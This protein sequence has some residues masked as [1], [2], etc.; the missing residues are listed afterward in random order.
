MF[1]SKQRHLIIPQS[2]HLRLVGTL[3]LLWGNDEF[4]LP[5]I[6][7]QSFVSGIGMHDR[8]YGFLDNAP[9]GEVA[10]AD[11]I[12]ITRRGFYTPWSNAAADLIAKHHLLRLARH[13]QSPERLRLTAEFEHAISGI[14]QQFGFSAELFARIDRITD[15]CDSVSFDFCFDKPANGNVTVFPRNA[16]STE[17]SIDYS[18]GQGIIRMNPWPFSVTY[19]QGYI[20]SYQQVGYPDRLDPVVLPWELFRE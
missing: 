20:I 3:A 10:E 1:K 5:D 16:K 18:V 14:L 6:D 15:L 19:Y 9:V 13:G 8:G 11:W 7:R 4:D 12:E 17:I 2:E